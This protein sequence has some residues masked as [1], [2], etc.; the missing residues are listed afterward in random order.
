MSTE[1]YITRFPQVI[2]LSTVN[3]FS[4]NFE[5]DC[6]WKSPRLYTIQCTEEPRNKASANE[7]SLVC[8]R[9]HMLGHVD[10]HMVSHPAIPAYFSG[11]MWWNRMV[12]R[13]WGETGWGEIDWDEKGWVRLAGARQYEEGEDT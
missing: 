13:G 5:G 8:K 1:G 7:K 9:H 12:R 3:L 6:F 2:F 4:F 10:R 11:C